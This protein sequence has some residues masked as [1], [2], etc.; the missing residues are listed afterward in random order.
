MQFNVEDILVNGRR[1][2]LG[3]PSGLH[4]F[5]RGRD[6]T[7]EYNNRVVAFL[8]LRWGRLICWEDYEDTERLAAWD[9]R[10]VPGG[11]HRV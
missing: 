5:V 3:S 9:Q 2:T 10:R 6:G 8:E 7:D 1:G 11:V 4:D